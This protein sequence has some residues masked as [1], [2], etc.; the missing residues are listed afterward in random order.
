MAVMRRAEYAPEDLSPPRY[1]GLIKSLVVP[2]PIAW[3][4]TISPDGVENLAPH[5][6]FTM[7][8]EVPPVAQFT[9]IGDK[10]SLRN[11]RATGEFV[12]SLAPE[13]LFELVNASATT[14]PPEISEFDALGIER[15]PAKTV[16]PSRVARSPAA[17]ECRLLETIEVGGGVI[18]L[19]HVQHV[20]VAESALTDGRPDIAKLA[21]L[22]RLGGIQWGLL[23]EIREIER[24][25]YSDA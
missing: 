14:Y 5:S 24:I 21:P 9:S 3:V 25:P 7:A 8:S 23:G 11:V 15:E 10:D 16:K 19:G 6:F 1:A 20:A 13:P 12:I 17:L 18:V 2:R 22:A 4:S